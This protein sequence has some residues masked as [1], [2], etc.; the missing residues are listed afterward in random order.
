[1]CPVYV[2]GLIGPGNR[3][4]VQPMVARAGKVGWER[5]HHFV[6]PGSVKASL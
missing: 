2:A 1:M 3:N 5:L 6:W 4:S